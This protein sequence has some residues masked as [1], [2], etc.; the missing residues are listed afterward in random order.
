M[1][2]CR[3]PRI[4]PQ[5]RTGPRTSRTALPPAARTGHRDLTFQCREPAAPALAPSRVPTAPALCPCPG[6]TVR[7]L[8]QAD[9]TKGQGVRDVSWE[10]PS[11]AR[12][13][14]QKGWGLLGHS[15]SSALGT[16]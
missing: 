5:Q 8:A 1:L 3:Q 12:D 14:S 2:T 10:G 15:L 16:D 7:A 13:L 6:G 11:R 9:R 4:A